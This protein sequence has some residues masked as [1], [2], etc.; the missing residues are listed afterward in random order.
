MYLARPG[1]TLDKI[2]ESFGV[3]L[4]DMFEY[5]G[6]SNTNLKSFQPVRVKNTTKEPDLDLVA[7]TNITVVS[8][9]MYTV[10]TGDTIPGIAKKFNVPEELIME[11]NKLSP[12]S[13]TPGIK[14]RI[15]PLKDN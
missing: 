1:A 12:G 11:M 10:K 2:A 6:T 9:F 15:Y 14:I 7:P 13:L 4:S 5:N 3:T 8:E